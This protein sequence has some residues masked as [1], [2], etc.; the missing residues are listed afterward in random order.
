M[1]LIDEQLKILQEEFEG[2]NLTLLPGGSQ[3]VMVPHVKLPDGWSQK[4][5]TVKFVILANYPHSA[6]DCFWTDQNLKLKNG[7]LPKNTNPQVIPG[8]SYNE[9]WFSWHAG[10]WSP[11]RDTLLTYMKVIE[12]RLRE[13]Q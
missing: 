10:R 1:N 2:A 4:E 7:T 6:P 13:A 3:L 12:A 5:I 9:L 8:T 11:N